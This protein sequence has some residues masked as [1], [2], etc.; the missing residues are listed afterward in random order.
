VLDAF[1]DAPA[2]AP[3]GPQFVAEFLEFQISLP[4]GREETVRRTLCDRA[5][6]AWRIAKPLDPAT[7]KPIKQGPT[8]PIATETLHNIFFSSG[9][10]DMAS[11]AQAIALLNDSLQPRKAFAADAPP[12]DVDFG[13]Q[14]WPLAMQNL[15]TVLWADQVFLPA[16]NDDPHV[17]CYLDSPRIVLF[18][19][20][21][22][23]REG[24]PDQITIDSEVDLRRDSIRAVASDASN[25][26]KAVRRKIWFGLLDGSLEHE[27]SAQGAFAM[28]GDGSQAISTSALL[29]APGAKLLQSR[30]ASGSWEK[31]AA[32]REVAA[33]LSGAL[34]SGDSVV[35]AD[36]VLHGGPSGWWAVSTTGDTRAVLGED[37]NGGRFGIS[38]NYIPRAPA[39]GNTGS[40]GSYLVSPDGKRSMSLGPKNT[41]KGGGNE[42]TTILSTVSVPGAITLGSV[43]TPKVL[44]A[45]GAV[46]AALAWYDFH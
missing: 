14:V 45:V 32:D 39:G 9:R 17:R 2:P 5:G 36:N 30:D 31:L 11:Y 35:V 26:G 8:G 42:Y 7:L 25:E 3:A 22:Q 16:L 18:S 33:G 21:A 29:G 1:G 40:G 12:A 20:N 37:L 44:I 19:L 24:A 10:H 34:A 43:L 13:Y 4:G 23:P 46:I 27:I 41:Q 28:G 15:A 6:A 38:N